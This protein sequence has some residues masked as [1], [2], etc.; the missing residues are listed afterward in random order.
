MFLYD[1]LQKEK[2]L[3]P[4]VVKQKASYVVM[5]P[6]KSKMRD[7]SIWDKY[8]QHVYSQLLRSEIPKAQKGKSSHQCLFA[9]MGAEHAKA[10]CK[11]LVKM[12]LKRAFQ[13]FFFTFHSSCTIL[14][15]SNFD[16]FFFHSFYDFSSFCIS[17]ELV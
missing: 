2:T 14:I 4:F 5:G 10:L 11:T 3:S 8:H 16:R 6:S 17:K 9:L 1:W 7:S 12:T 15:M 13:Q